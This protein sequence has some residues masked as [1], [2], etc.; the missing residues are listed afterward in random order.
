[1]STISSILSN[2]KGDLSYFS[3][4]FAL[5]TSSFALAATVV[6]GKGDSHF[7]TYVASAKTLCLL[8]V[9]EFSSLHYDLELPIIGQIFFWSYIAI[10]YILCL[11][12]LLAIIIDA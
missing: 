5:I 9:G 7:S 6:F 11:N 1:M 8:L 3:L 2:A 12:V 10:S 4:L